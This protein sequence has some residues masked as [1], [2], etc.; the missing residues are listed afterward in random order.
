MMNDACIFALARQGMGWGNYERDGRWYFDMAVLYASSGI[1][2]HVG[3]V[4]Q[5]PRPSGAPTTYI[6]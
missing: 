3:K 4:L 1:T 6:L 2:T 5:N